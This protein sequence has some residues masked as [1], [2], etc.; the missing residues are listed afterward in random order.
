MIDSDP[1]SQT[2]PRGLSFDLTSPVGQIA[3]RA[4]SHEGLD[5]IGS[6]LDNLAGDAIDAL[7]RH[8]GSEERASFGTIDQ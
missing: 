1:A 3:P 4:R 6:I 2:D 8:E 5:A 7:L